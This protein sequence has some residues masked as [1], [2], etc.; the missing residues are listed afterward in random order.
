MYFSYLSTSQVSA[1]V[2]ETCFCPL[3]WVHDIPGVP[4][5]M[6][7][8]FVRNVVEVAKRQNAK[9]VTKKSPI[10]PEALTACCNEYEHSRELPIRRDISMALLLLQGSFVLMNLQP[11]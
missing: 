9:P 11:L 2:I 3:K 7:S 4:N 8:P 1:S 10:S 6:V 5:P